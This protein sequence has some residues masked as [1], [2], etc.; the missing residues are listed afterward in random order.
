LS[1]AASG[2][3][4]A[5]RSEPPAASTQRLD[6]S[7]VLPAECDRLDKAVPHPRLVADADLEQALLSY[8][9]A[10]EVANAAIAA[11][12]ACKAK[13]RARYAKK[14]TSTGNRS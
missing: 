1:I 10:L 6:L 5:P 8:A 4:T 12:A 2:C 14:L 7:V 3:S 11:D 9:A 13:L